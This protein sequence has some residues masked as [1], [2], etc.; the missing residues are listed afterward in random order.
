MYKYIGAWGDDGAP[1][2]RNGGTDERDARPHRR[3]YRGVSLYISTHARKLCWLRIHM[4]IYTVYASRSRACAIKRI[5]IT[6][7]SGADTC[8][9]KVH[10]Q[11]SFD[12]HYIKTLI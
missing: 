12:Q 10:Q 4:Y 9:F 5:R 6:R 7:A 3:D 1:G 11:I 2:D 8:R